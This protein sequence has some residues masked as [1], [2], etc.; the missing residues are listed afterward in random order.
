MGT[1][2]PAANKE[3]CSPSAAQPGPG[4]SPG[5]PSRRSRRQRS[6]LPRPR[7]GSGRKEECGRRASCARRGAD[8]SQRGAA[9]QGAPGPFRA[10]TAPVEAE[11]GAACLSLN[12]VPGTRVPMQPPGAAAGSNA[13]CSAPGAAQPEVSRSLARRVPGGQKVP[14][15]PMVCAGHLPG[16]RVHGF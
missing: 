9:S 16:T 5:L 6:P 13:R 12:S 8:G 2:H 15:R 3:T 4:C 10:P 7:G 1:S 14:A 11:G